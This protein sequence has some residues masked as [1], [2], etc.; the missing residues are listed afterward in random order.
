MPYTYTQKHIY[1]QKHTHMHRH[2]IPEILNVKNDMIKTVE[3]YI[4]EY[5]QSSWDRGDF[6]KHD[7]KSRDNNEREYQFGYEK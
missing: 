1:M 4:L 7:P 2:L 5:L 6:S 3:E